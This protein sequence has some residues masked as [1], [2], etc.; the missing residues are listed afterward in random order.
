[1]I[2]LGSNVLE[3]GDFLKTHTQ[4]FNNL[5][6]KG[7]PF[8]QQDIIVPDNWNITTPGAASNS[9]AEFEHVFFDNNNAMRMKCQSYFTVFNRTRYDISDY[10]LRFT[11]HST[12]KSKLYI[13]VHTY[14]KDKTW[15]SFKD[16]YVFHY[17]PMSFSQ[18][19]SLLLTR[20]D[21]PSEAHFFT[22]C[23]KLVFGEVFISDT[24]LS[25]LVSHN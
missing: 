16:L 14:K 3:N 1:M 2:S 7:V 9:F 22:L 13:S 12:V 10:L 15:N 21:F 25:P 24:S 5:K 20:E 4:T 23:F 8:F 17:D 11:I 18:R 6:Q 19:Y